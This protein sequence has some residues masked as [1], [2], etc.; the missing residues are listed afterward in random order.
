VALGTGYSRVSGTR[1]A[2]AL[3]SQIRIPARPNRTKR[4]TAVWTRLRGVEEVSRRAGQ[5]Y[6][7]EDDRTTQ[8]DAPHKLNL[9]PDSTLVPA[10]ESTPAQ[11]PKPP[12]HQL[13]PHHPLCSLSLC[14][15]VRLRGEGEGWGWGSGGYGSPGSSAGG[16][17][18]A[19]RAAAPSA[20]DGLR[21]LYARLAE[22]Y[23]TKLDDNN[24]KQLF[25]YLKGAQ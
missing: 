15:F 21:G 22:R 10:P 25:E 11:L 24:C 3:I 5:A 9:D 4:I 12:P 17:R 23:S 14:V 2:R 7:G 13:P 16:A 18:G 19:A 6:R 8:S 20:A 1:G